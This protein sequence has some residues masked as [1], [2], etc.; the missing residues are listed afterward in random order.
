MVWGLV[1]MQSG[2]VVRLLPGV[3]RRVLGGGERQPWW[4]PRRVLTVV[5]ADIDTGPGV[6]A[7]WMVWRPGAAGAWEYVEFLEWYDGQWRYVGGGNSAVDDPS[8]VDVD[9]D[10]IEIRCGAG[11]L[12]LTRR[13]DPPRSLEPSKRP[14]GS[15]ASASPWGRTSTTSSSATAGSACRS[16]AGLLLSGRARRSGG[17][18]V[19]PS[20]LSGA[21]AASSPVSAR[22]TAWTVIRGRG[23]GGSWRGSRRL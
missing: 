19:P 17:G 1:G 18:R 14:P 2:L 13:L 20:W 7:V 6:G 11:A 21:T 3:V 4:M 16:S 10:V 22:S 5:S 9:V 8:D 15:P 23:C 12:S